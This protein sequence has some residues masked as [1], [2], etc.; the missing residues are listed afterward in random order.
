MQ[1]F[2]WPVIATIIYN[3]TAIQR[4]APPQFACFVLQVLHLACLH[5]QGAT[6]PAKIVYVFFSS[7]REKKHRSSS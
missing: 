5:E 1:I 6:G 2:L 4:P 7:L 3:L